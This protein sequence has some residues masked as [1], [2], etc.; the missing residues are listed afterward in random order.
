MTTTFPLS[1]L[2]QEG[3]E[4]DVTVISDSEESDE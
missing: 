1:G 2:M 4:L 3:H